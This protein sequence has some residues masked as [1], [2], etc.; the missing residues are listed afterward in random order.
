MIRLN[1]V[2][3]GQT[4][5]AFVDEVLAIP[6]ADVDVFVSARCV[7]TSRRQVRIYRGGLVSY[8]KLKGDLRRWMRQDRHPECWFTTMI[9]LYGLNRLRDEFPGF[10]GIRLE[11]DPRR[12]VAALE[13]AFAADIDHPRFIPYLQLHEFEAL[14]LS[15]PQKLDWEFIDRG[16]EIARLVE[17]ASTVES[18]ELIDDG[19]DTSPSHQIIRFIPEY[20]GRKP[21]AGPLVAGKIGLPT[22]RQKC[23]HFAEWVDRLEALGQQVKG[24]V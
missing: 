9:D 11:H 5:E 15:D 22:L 23:P 3:E 13:Q 24:D 16:R 4:E 7:E 18:P 6:L 10:S 1:L 12:R 8:E 21:S 17:L 19:E 2:V 14:I 20:Q